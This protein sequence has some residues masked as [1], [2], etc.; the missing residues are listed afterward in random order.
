[1]PTFFSY[2]TLETLHLETSRG[3]VKPSRHEEND[4]RNETYHKIFKGPVLS[5]PFSKPIGKIITINNWGNC[6]PKQFG[7]V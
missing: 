7:P 5:P 3:H 1:M 6:D 4:T 2:L